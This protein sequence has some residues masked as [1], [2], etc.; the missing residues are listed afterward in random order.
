MLSIISHADQRGSIKLW[1]CYPG[2]IEDNLVVKK[3]S[4]CQT[5]RA[6]FCDLPENC[7]VTSFEVFGIYIQ[8]SAR[9]IQRGGWILHEFSAVYPV[10]S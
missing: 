3:D 4:D 2:K 5:V 10:Y 1:L 8:C 7:T 9:D 6:L